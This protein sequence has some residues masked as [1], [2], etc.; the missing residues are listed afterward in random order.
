VTVTFAPGTSI[1]ALIVG[2]CVVL[3]VVAGGF[4]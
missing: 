2:V 4:S 1:V 3:V